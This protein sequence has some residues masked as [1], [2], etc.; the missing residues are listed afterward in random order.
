MTRKYSSISVETTLA[1]GISNSATTMT[2]AASTASA[3]LGG[4]TLGG[5]NVDQFTVAIDPDTTNEEIVFVT[6]VTTD[7]LTI[8]RGRSGSTGVSHSGGA[9]VKHVLT[10]DDLNA[11]ATLTDAQT[12]SSKTLASPIV[13]GTLTAGASVG[14]SGQILS[15]TG[16]G[17]QWVA[18][19]TDSSSSLQDAILMD[20]MDAY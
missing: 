7:T 10:S 17:I 20:V 1:N 8:V 5:S 15:S 19:I 4:I 12:L 2:V 11:Y 3:L 14:T 18:S 16:T 13:T 9:T 6:G